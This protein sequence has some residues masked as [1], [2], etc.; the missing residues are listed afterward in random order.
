MKD[1][2]VYYYITLK[3]NLERGG[4]L[5]EKGGGAGTGMR[6]VHS[7]LIS[8]QE[9]IKLIQFEFYNWIFNLLRNWV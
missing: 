7:Q 9:K 2:T 3:T 4:D 6:K 5:L 1:K 8:Y